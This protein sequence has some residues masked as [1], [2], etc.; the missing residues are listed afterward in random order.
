MQAPRPPSP[1]KN[2][3]QEG[4]AVVL[5]LM[6]QQVDTQKERGTHSRPPRQVSGK[7]GLEPISFAHVLPIQG[8]YPDSVPLLMLD[9]NG[10]QQTT[11]VPMMG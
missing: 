1:P 7:I 5:H 3:R 8:F 6:G 2:E 10:G 11:S 4:W 9:V